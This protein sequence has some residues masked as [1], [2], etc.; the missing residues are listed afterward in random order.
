MGGKVA[1]K[2]EATRARNEI[3]IKIKNLQKRGTKQNNKLISRK[4]LK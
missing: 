3:T 1:S 4:N 2:E